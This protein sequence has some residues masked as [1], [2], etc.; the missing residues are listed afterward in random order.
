[1]CTHTHTYAG[2]ALALVRDAVRPARPAAN[3]I[4]RACVYLGVPICGTFVIVLLPSTHERVCVVADG[5]FA[6]LWVHSVRTAAGV[7]VLE[8]VFSNGRFTHVWRVY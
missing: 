6:C 5:E 8:D 4:V 1:M 7:L 3:T 2:H